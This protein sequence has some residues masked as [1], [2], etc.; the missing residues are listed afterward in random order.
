VPGVVTRRSFCSPLRNNLVV[1]I[2]NNF[3]DD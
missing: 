1:D 2:V 3:I